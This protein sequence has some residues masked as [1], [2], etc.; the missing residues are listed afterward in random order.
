LSRQAFL[1]MCR[2]EEGIKRIDGILR[3]R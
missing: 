2:R 3:E 1:H